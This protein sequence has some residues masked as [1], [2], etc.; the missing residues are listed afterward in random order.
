MH[1]SSAVSALHRLQKVFVKKE[2]NNAITDTFLWTEFSR[3]HLKT[4]SLSL[5][6]SLIRM[7]VLYLT[8]VKSRKESK[9]ELPL[10]ISANS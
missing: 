10:L 5:A 8:R 6:S 7:V 2:Q 1:R 9:R 4:L 3:D